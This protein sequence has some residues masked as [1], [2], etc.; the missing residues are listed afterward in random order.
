M[1]GKKLPP[2][3]I[4]AEGEGWAF[5]EMATDVYCGA[6]YDEETRLVRLGDAVRLERSK[7]K[8]KRAYNYRILV[9]ERMRVRAKVRTM[10]KEHRRLKKMV[11]RK[12]AEV[13]RLRKKHGFG[14]FPY[15]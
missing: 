2:E 12:W 4:R 7:P 11:R 3:V 10:E 9:E 8:D 15:F 1:S 14:L 5:S 13:N 6:M